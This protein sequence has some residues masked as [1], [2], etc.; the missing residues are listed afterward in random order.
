MMSTDSA[1][2][3]AF[4]GLKAPVIKAHGNSSAEAITSAISQI[5]RMIESDVTGKLLEHFENRVE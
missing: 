4:I 2:G 3:A 5:H 1:G